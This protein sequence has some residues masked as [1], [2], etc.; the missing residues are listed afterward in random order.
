MNFLTVRQFAEKHKAFSISSLRWLLFI[1]AGF[2]SACC[3][4]IRGR[5]LLK[6]QAVLDW[7]DRQREGGG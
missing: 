2:R 3:H 7:V 4:K 1:D 5:V 6:E